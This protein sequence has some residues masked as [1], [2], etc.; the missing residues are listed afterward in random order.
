MNGTPLGVWQ[1]NPL[2]NNVNIPDYVM[3]T[4]P[5]ARRYTQN[6]SIYKGD[7]SRKSTYFPF[8]YSYPK[9]GYTEY[10]KTHSERHTMPFSQAI[11]LKKRAWTD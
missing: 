2:K 7:T 1:Q 11:T 10:Q 4:P 5:P 9:Q 3:L 8:V 6:N